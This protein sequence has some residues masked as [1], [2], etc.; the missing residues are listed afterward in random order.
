MPAY[1]MVHVT[2]FQK[3]ALKHDGM[4]PMTELSGV[5]STRSRKRGV[6]PHSSG[7][8][9]ND[10]VPHRPALSTSLPCPQTGEPYL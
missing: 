1:L 3:E 2:T 10:T 5:D 6:N 8:L 9:V 7:T 4:T